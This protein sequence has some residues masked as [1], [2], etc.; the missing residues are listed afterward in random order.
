MSHLDQGTIPMP[1]QDVESARVT[2]SGFAALAPD[3]QDGMYRRLS[4]AALVYTGAW[5][6]NYLYFTLFIDHVVDPIWHIVS[7]L[8]IAAGIAVYVLGRKR[9]IPPR[10]FSNFAAAFEVL[11]ALGIM[12][13][14]W[15]WEHNGVEMLERMAVALEIPK[16]DILSRLVLPL[17]ANNA[18]VLYH[19]GV[20][21]V[22]VW[23]LVY[24]LVVP[25]RL[26]RTIVTTLLA[27]AV[28]PAFLG[29]SLLA[30]GIPDTVRPWIVDY[31]LDTTVPVLICAGISITSSRVV[32]R[33]TRDLSEARRMGSYRLEEKIGEGGMGEVWKAKHRM[34]VRP[35]AIKLVRSPDGDD[36]GRPT[37]TAV[38]RFQ[39][40]AQA[41]AE[42]SSPHSIELY[43]FGITDDG[44]F[45]YVME[46]LRGV[47]LRT[48]VER[49][50][51]LP[52]ERV[53]H[54]LRQACHS[55][56]DA[57]DLG[58]VHRDVK[59]ANL[60]VCRRGSDLDFV[61]VLDFGLV[62]HMGALDH[63][64]PQLTIDG[65]AGGTPAFMAPEMAR[66]RDDVDGRADLYALGCVGYWLLTGTLVFE[67]DSAVAVL[68][69]HL[70]ET[71]VPPSAR[72]ELPVPADLEGLLMACLA[73]NP[74][75]RPASARELADA[76]AACA[77]GLEP[78]SQQ[79]AADWWQLHLPQHYR[80]PAA[81]PVPAAS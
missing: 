14:A 2:D 19:E 34:L 67:G 26:G 28:V 57:H 78:W 44:T 35:A 69:R 17:D 45:Y 16:G 7:N 70:G 1:R 66:S 36:A 56:A 5:L 47:D 21:W 65:F 10:H 60:F 49:Y 27:A 64:T 54:I 43:D 20:S 32:Y 71:P 72:T 6:A 63:D 12:A 31:L 62:K 4:G 33:L 25:A 77:R 38:R 30:N 40:E 75:D 3:V 53:I 68:A 74:D 52:P 18:R 11:G 48:L 81:F 42:L 29:L 73:K 13:G 37:E 59:P 50:G 24:P 15:G 80:T 58:I 8:S 39:Q 46:L 79:R 51:P 41:T 61:K 76:L 9:R 22:A 23:M 55:L